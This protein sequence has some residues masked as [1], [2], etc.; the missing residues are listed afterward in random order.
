MWF[1]TRRASAPTA[2]N[3][4]GR[5]PLGHTRSINSQLVP[6]AC[7]FAPP[8]VSRDRRA[9]R[10][11]VILG[12]PIKSTGGPMVRFDNGVSAAAVS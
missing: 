5:C 10:Y 3:F 4:R 1:A 6:G 2:R 7:Q 12:L 9:V 11:V 8:L